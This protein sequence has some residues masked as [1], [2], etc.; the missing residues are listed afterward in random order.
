M[1][2]GV[3]HGSEDADGRGEH[4]DVGELEHRFG[5]T[6]GEGE[7][8]AALGFGDERES[9]G[10]ENAEDDD[11]QDLV[12]GDGLGDVLGK[13]V[14]DELRSAVRGGIERF[15]RG[16]GREAD[17]LS[18]AADVDGGEADQQRDGGD[19]FEV[20]EGLEAEA[21]DFFE[22]GVAGDTDDERAKEERGDDDANEAKENGAEELEVGGG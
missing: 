17:A 9:H 2:D 8:G 16:G 20:D 11:L 6:F 3:G 13:D 1:A 18:G 12:F 10:E 21:A 5:E 14:D 4:D 19:D 22:V 7:H 15:G